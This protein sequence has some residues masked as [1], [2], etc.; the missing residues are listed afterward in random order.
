MDKSFATF[1][2]S[3]RPLRL[4]ILTAKVAKETLARFIGERY[5]WNTAKEQS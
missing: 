3:L 1:A 4:K 5:P 2:V